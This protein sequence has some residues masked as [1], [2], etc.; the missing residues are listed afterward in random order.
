M[1]AVLE[2]TM[3]SKLRDMIKT[4]QSNDSTREEKLAF[5]DNDDIAFKPT[6][7]GGKQENMKII[8]HQLKSRD[9]S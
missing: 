7:F 1:T 8:R 4:V 6:E 5:C 3:L 9:K 2:E